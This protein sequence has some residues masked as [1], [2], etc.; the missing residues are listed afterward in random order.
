MSTEG[1]TALFERVSNDDDFRRRLEEAPTAEDK[2]RIVTEAG[3][4]VDRDDLATMKSLA[5]LDELSDDELAQT[6]GGTPSGWILAEEGQGRVLGAGALA[7]AA[8]MSR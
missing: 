7:V 3:F 8:V 2:R 4:D 1:A 6:V 5:G